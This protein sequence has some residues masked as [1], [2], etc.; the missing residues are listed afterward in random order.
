MNILLHTQIRSPFFTAHTHSLTLF[1]PHTLKQVFALT[2]LWHLSGNLFM[3]SI[4]NVDVVK[5]RKKQRARE[6]ENDR[7]KN[8]TDLENL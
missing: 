4:I 1:S 7:K 2:S 8:K 6:R 3:I 5:F